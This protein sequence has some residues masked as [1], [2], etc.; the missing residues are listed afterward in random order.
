MTNVNPE[1]S[2]SSA[3]RARHAADSDSAAA[4]P[5]SASK[6]P[7]RGV[8]MVLIAV[9]VMLGMWALYAMTSDGSEDTAQDAPA[10]DAAVSGPATGGAE[11]D[12]ATGGA[13]GEADKNKDAAENER[14][15]DADADS[16][17]ADQAGAER[18]ESRE[19]NAEAGAAAGNADRP[20]AEIPVNV[21]NNSGRAN[22]A[23]DE[24]ER[25]KTEKF[26]VAE[27]GNISD[28]VLVAPQTTVF[29]PQGDA[30]AEN[31][32]KEVAAQYYGGNVPAEAIA[33]YPAELTGDYTKGDAVVVVLAV[34]QA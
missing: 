19:G 5:A 7:L 2:A 34:P 32:A 31:L 14:P 15:A 23:A 30:A 24:A 25:L 10:N 22:Y 16:E 13:E 12:V 17:N 20:Q 28:D 4:A 26:K 21:F 1:N 3:D 8:A 11:G 27:V 29:F 9:A 18:K 33:P 6:L